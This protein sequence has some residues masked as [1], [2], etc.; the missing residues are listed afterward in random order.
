[1]PMIP[2]P[3]TRRDFVIALLAVSATLC[4][5]AAA[6]E[7]PAILPSTAFDWNAFPVRTTEVGSSRQIVR[8][9]TATL[10]ELE[11]HVTTLKAGLASHAPHKHTNEELL[12]VREGTVEALVNGEWK[13]VGPGSVIFQASNS[14]HGVRNVGT[15]AATYHIVNWSAPGKL[16]TNGPR[17]E[18]CGTCGPVTV[19][20]YPLTVARRPLSAIRCS[21]LVARPGKLSGTPGWRNWQTLGT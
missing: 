9:P 11:M 20:R 16:K 19:V 13:R 12:I 17:G 6:Q 18:L 3:I 15:T 5:V 7:K 10:D 21:P 4:V 1:M 8:Q 14:C 2:S